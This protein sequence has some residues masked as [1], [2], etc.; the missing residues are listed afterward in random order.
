MSEAPNVEFVGPFETTKV[1]V[2]G[3]TVPFLTAH[4]RAGGDVSLTLDDRFGLDL[5][6]FEYEQVVPFIA[7][8]IAVALGYTCHPPADW[9]EP[10]KS[11]PFT[12]LVGVGS[13]ETHDPFEE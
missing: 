8:C 1:V 9:D 5:S 12:R 11:H 6:V 2:E 4:V 7:N 10:I 13:V 3:R